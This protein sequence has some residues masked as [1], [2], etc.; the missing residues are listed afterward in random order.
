MA[1]HFNFRN[2]GNITFRC[3]LYNLF[4]LFLC[5]KATIFYIIISCAGITANDSSISPSTNLSKFGIFFY[6]NPPALVF[7]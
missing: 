2:N 4:Y 6:F 5:I 3:I 1:R 7:G